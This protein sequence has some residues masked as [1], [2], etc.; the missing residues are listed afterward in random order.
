MVPWVF[1]VS[2]ATCMIGSITIGKLSDKVRCNV[3]LI[4]HLITLI[5]G[6]GAVFAGRY[7]GISEIFFGAGAL[8]GISDAIS[9]TFIPSMLMKDV[10]QAISGALSGTHPL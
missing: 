5:L 1:A 7:L 4:I 3:V 6:Y 2:G 9:N 10:P 8:F